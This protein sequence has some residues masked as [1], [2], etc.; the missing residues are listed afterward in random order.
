MKKKKDSKRGKSTSSL[1]WHIV[2]LVKYRFDFMSCCAVE[3]EALILNEM[4][5]LISAASLPFASLTGLPTRDSPAFWGKDQECGY[6][7]FFLFLRRVAACRFTHGERSAG[8]C[9]VSPRLR[10]CL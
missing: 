7:G 4:P 3:R 10:R 2:R 5:Q 8:G 1:H 6:I 9:T